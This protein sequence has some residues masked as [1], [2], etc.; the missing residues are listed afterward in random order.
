MPSTPPGAK[1]S[2]W[3]W[4]NANQ[5]LA[6]WVLGTEVWRTTATAITT[7]VA[8]TFSGLAT[9]TA[10]MK[11]TSPTVPIGYG[12]GAGSA[13]VTQVTNRATAVAV[14]TVTGQIQTDTTSLAAE[15]SA[16][17]AV[18]ATGLVTATDVVV[19]SQVSGS[20]GGNT[21]LTV[22]AVAADSFSIRVSNNNAAAG[23]AET[24]AIIMNY[25]VIKGSIT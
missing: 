3:R 17:F 20:N 1:T 9:F 7:L 5:R 21:D 22:Y 14:T 15:V 23:A 16:V 10:G 19:V 11:S 25:T 24:G 8:Q 4:D 13:K 6:T 18:T 12:V 2:G